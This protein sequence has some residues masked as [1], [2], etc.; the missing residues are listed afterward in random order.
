LAADHFYVDAAEVELVRCPGRYDVIVMENL[1][2]GILLGA[3]PLDQPGRASRR[4]GSLR[5]GSADRSR[6]ADGTR[7]GKSQTADLGGHAPTHAPSQ[8]VVR[9]AAGT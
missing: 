2:S 7:K 8:A 5:R 4:H 1:L 9:R 3:L 6:R